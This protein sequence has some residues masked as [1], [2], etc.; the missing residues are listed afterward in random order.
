MNSWFTKINKQL[1]EIGAAPQCATALQAMLIAINNAGEFPEPELSLDGPEGAGDVE[2]VFEFG[3]RRVIT[4]AAHGDD[5]EPEDAPPDERLPTSAD[6]A[7][8]SHGMQP[9]DLV[10]FFRA[11]QANAEKVD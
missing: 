3:G 7:V 2:A 6:V 1:S 8:Y 11:V 10:D 4:V 9:W 5:W